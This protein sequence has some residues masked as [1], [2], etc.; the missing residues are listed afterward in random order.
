MSGSAVNHEI[1]KNSSA[2]YCSLVTNES[3][4]VAKYAL[5]HHRTPNASCRCDRSSAGI[6]LWL[7]LI[8]L[9]LVAKALVWGWGLALADAAAAVCR[10]Q[11]EALTIIPSLNE[12]VFVLNMPKE[13]YFAQ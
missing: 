8:R 1:R 13:D 6:F 5:L 11:F 12:R 7:R 2:S 4:Y 10:G 3:A 9:K